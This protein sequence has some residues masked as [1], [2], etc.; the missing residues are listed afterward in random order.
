[1][2]NNIV[3]PLPNILNM[4]ISFAIIAACLSV[5]ACTNQ[6]PTQQAPSTPEGQAVSCDNL[7]HLSIV[8]MYSDGTI[9]HYEDIDYPVQDCKAL[10]DGTVLLSKPG[11]KFVQQ[12][13]PAV[14]ASQ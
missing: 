12:P 7:G 4:K 1:M 13:A 8:H 6:S 9:S 2:A 11:T 10:P 3:E 5:V 14:P